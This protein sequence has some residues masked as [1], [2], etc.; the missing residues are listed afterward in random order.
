M[1]NDIKNAYD[2]VADHFNLTRK[3]ALPSQLIDFKQYLANGQQVLDLGCGSGR[4]I[5]IL[6]DFEIDCIF[7]PEYLL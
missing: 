2:Q 4:I 1:N 6:K 7:I 3:R 5:R